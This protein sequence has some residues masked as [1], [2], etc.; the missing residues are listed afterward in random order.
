MGRVLGIRAVAVRRILELLG[1]R[2]NKL[3][4]DSSVA[5]GCGVPRWDR[6]AVHDDWHLERAVTAIGSAAQATGGTAVPDALTGPIG[7][8]QGG[9]VGR[10]QT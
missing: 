9:A 3:V 2:S 10:T 4:T 1:Y 6:F 7:R 8:Q 5:A